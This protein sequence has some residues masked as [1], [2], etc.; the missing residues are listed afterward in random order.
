VQSKNCYRYKNSKF[1]RNLVNICQLRIYRQVFRN[2]EQLALLESC[3]TED[4]R[5][6][7]AVRV[8]ASEDKKCNCLLL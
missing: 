2:F 1:L 6:F 4:V 5:R 8:V 3:Y 7:A